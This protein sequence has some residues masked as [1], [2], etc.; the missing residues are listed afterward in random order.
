MRELKPLADKM[1]WE[2][3]DKLDNPQEWEPIFSFDNPHTHVKALA[4]EL[5]KFGIVEGQ[6]TFPLPKYG[7]D[8]HKAVEHVHGTLTSQMNTVH[9]RVRTKQNLQW[10]KNKLRDQ[11]Y[12]LK[13]SHMQKDVDTLPDTLR[14]IATPVSENGTG[15]NWAPTKLA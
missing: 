5:P 9:K 6:N 12:A 10:Y 3:K 7:G 1:L 13:P 15:G 11:F 8:I 2:N 4:D 14:V